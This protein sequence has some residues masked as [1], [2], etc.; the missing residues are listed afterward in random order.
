MP[1][2]DAR[3]LPP[4][5]EHTRGPWE[6]DKGRDSITI[7]PAWVAADLYTPNDNVCDVDLRYKNAE[8]NALLLASAPDLL[9]ACR[10]ALEAVREEFGDGPTARTL[11]SA[12][13]KATGVVC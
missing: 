11:A 2:S 6:I 4:P 7:G 13:A 8:A 3:F 5:S 9:A 10:T 12:I 1:K